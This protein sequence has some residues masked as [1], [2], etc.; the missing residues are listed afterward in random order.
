[1]YIHCIK[2][3]KRC[4]TVLF[5]SYKG[6]NV[7][8]YQT[9]VTLQLVCGSTSL[10]CS[11]MKLQLLQHPI[12]RFSYTQDPTMLFNSIQIK[13]VTTQIINK[14]CRYEIIRIE[15][16]TEIRL[17]GLYL[18][19]GKGLKTVKLF[20]QAP[21][22][23]NYCSHEWPITDQIAINQSELSMVIFDERIISPIKM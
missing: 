9:E 17:A 13:Y 6:V 20:H 8:R 2:Y 15:Y 23:V 4:I 21:Q 10:Y 19:I 14:Q 18:L 12:L 11:Y 3:I 22:F 16:N 1:M 5:A 7:R